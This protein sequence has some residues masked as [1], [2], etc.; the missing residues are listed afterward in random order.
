M[1]GSLSIEALMDGSGLAAD[2]QAIRELVE[3]WVVWRDSGDWVRLRSTWHDDGRMIA[4]WFQGPADQFIDVCR[5]GWSNGMRSWHTLGGMT[6]EVSGPRAVA[7]SKTTIA[8]RT[9]VEDVLCDVVCTGRFYD[10]LE[11]R[12][13]RWGLVLR[14]PVYE[15]DR[16][17]P[18]DPAAHLKLDEKLLA[19]FPCGYRHLAYAQTKA[20]YTVNRHLPGTD[21]PEIDSLYRQAA[22][23]LRGEA[24]T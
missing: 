23:W 10:F 17:D 2:R 7:Q 6:I 15:K 14:Q 12:P 11:K 3:S 22:A 8:Q 1:P 4:T 9:P 24:L 13:G 20:G 5:K 16:I 19:L 21:G 18:V